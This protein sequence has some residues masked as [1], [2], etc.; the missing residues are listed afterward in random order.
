MG[1]FGKYFDRW[2]NPNKG[3]EGLEQARAALSTSCARL[4]RGNC[5]LLF[6]E[7]G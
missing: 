2:F 3:H 7:G 4:R 6:P 1:L 5:V